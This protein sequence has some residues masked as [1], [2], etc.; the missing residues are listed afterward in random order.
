M[1]SCAR[2]S[3][4]VRRAFRIMMKIPWFYARVWESW[5]GDDAAPK[6]TTLH[7]CTDL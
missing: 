6:L 3:L 1:S 5:I 7:T 2:L 4:S